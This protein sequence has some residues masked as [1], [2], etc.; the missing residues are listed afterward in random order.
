MSTNPNRHVQ[1]V[2]QNIAASYIVLGVNTV[3]SSIIAY[4]AH[5]NAVPLYLALIYGVGVFFVVA[6]SVYVIGLL[7]NMFRHP[8]EAG[9][10]TPTLRQSEKDELE[11]QVKELKESNF[12][13]QEKKEEQKD[14][15]VLRESERDALQSKI[16]AHKWLYEIAE[17]DKNDLSVLVQVQSVVWNPHYLSERLPYT[18]FTFTIFNGSVYEVS[19]DK[20]INGYVTFAEQRLSGNIRL[21]EK[22]AKTFPH[23]ATRRLRIY[24]PLSKEDVALIQTA[25]ELPDMGFCFGFEK[26]VIKISGKDIELQPL[27]LPSNIYASSTSYL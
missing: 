6:V 24:Y 20:D 15:I 3:I 22:T 19:V 9:I 13:L 4:S 2:A 23:G 18:E 8:I 5:S 14:R 25:P 10:E 16:D 21:A 17:Y 11:K 1:S 27:S 12:Q 7:V 26:L